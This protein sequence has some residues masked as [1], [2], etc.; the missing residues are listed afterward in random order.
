MKNCLIYAR[1]STKDQETQNQIDQLR[2]YAAK[3][4]WEVMEEVIDVC[5]GGKAAK[6]VSVR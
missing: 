6:D 1:C 3:Q 4:G 2:A 5:S